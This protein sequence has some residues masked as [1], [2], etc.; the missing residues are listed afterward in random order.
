[1]FRTPSDLDSIFCSAIELDSPADR[2]AYLA[3]A[4]GTDDALR[5]DVETLVAAHFRADR[6]LTDPPVPPAPPAPAGAEGPGA[7]VGPYTLLEPIGEGGMGVVYVAEQAEPVRRRVALKLIK[8]GMDSRQ[9]VAR[10]EAERQALALMDHPNIARILDAGTTASGRPYFAM[11]LVP[12]E[13]ITDYCDRAALAPR[14]RLRL[15]AQVCRAVQHAHQKGIIHRDLKPGNVLVALHDGT[16]VPKVIDFGVAKAIGQPLTDGSLCTRFA[17]L[18]GTPLYMAP[19]QAAL[20]GLDVDT[21]VDVYALGVLLYELLTG[22]TPFN[23]DALLRLG[24]DEVRRI[25]REEEPPRPSRRVG[26]LGAEERSGACGRRGLTDRQLVRLLRGDLDWVSMKA[27]EK[28]RNRR[29][30]SAGAFAADVERFLADEPVEARPASAWY[31]LR[32]AA[33]R[34]R[35]A[36]AATGLVAAT[37][38]AGTAVSIWQAVRA[39]ESRLQA[40]A[41]ERQATKDRVRAEAAEQRARSEAAVARAVNEFLQADL[42]GQAAATPGE[43]DATGEPYL[44]VKEALDR[45]STRIGDRF[46]TQP[47]V[48]A[49]IRTAIGEAYYKLHADDLAAPHFERAVALRREHLGPDH[50][51]TLRSVFSLAGAWSWAGRHSDAIALFQE[52]FECRR[53]A[54][55]LDHPDTLT[56]LGRLAGTYAICG[57]FEHAVRLWEQVAERQRILFGPRAPSTLATLHQLA[58]CYGGAGRV[59]ESVALYEKVLTDFRHVFGP[60]APETIGCT[61]TFAQ[62]WLRNGQLDRAEGLLRGALGAVQ[63]RGDSLLRRMQAANTSG[64]LALTLVLKGQPAEAEPLAREA[65]TTFEKYQPHDPR[66][67]HWV[68]VWGESLASQ[69]KDAAA[70]PLLVRGY[71]GVKQREALLRGIDRGQVAQ[72]AERLVRFFE[73]TGQ[74]D[75][76]RAWRE[77]LHAATPG[78]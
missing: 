20:G 14:D 32:K 75:Q 66:Y 51:D 69:R 55:G 3:G 30:E 56:A 17:Q 6:F 78:R 70:E 24:L 23:R 63:Q 40:E 58:M 44:T 29:Y 62:I 77:K 76:A 65:A 72:A 27:L 50:P 7:V 45:A 53:Q 35:A 33:R 49:A 73:V 18:V 47:L 8:P 19:E 5:R 60:A 1:V 36:L 4:C 39:T 28:D 43:L 68:S 21:R 11:E 54:L 31:R 41:A 59:S 10:F 26:A 71:E 46:R 9:V 64:W 22:T 25:I 16:P 37:L 13:P 15:F 34:N 38:L 48:E 74:P 12:G 2:A 57:Q 52:A 61:L 42:L 67:F